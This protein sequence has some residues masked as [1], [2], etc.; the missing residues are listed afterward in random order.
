MNKDKIQDKLNELFSSY[1]IVFWNDPECE[2]EDML[3]SLH[4]KDVSVVRPDEI[5][6]LKTKVSLEIDNPN[7]K[8]LVYS[9]S[10]ILQY[11]DDWLLDIRLYSYQF[12]ADTASMIVEELGLHHHF[13]REHITKRK[14]FFASKERI[15]K[16]K[17]M[18]SPQDLEQDIDRKMLAVLVKTE[19]DRFFYIV[20]AVFNSYPKDEG[21]DVLP[22]RFLD[23]K[24]M[25]LEDV[26]WGLAKENFGYH[27]EN[28][29]LRHFLTCLL[30]SDLYVSIGSALPDSVRQFILPEIATHNA[31]VCMS[32]W[33]D[34]VRMTASYDQLSEMVGESVAVERYLSEISLDVLKSAVTFFAV[35]KICASKCRDYVLEHKDTL[36]KDY[37]ISICRTRQEMH[38]ANKRLG[39]E[40]IPREGL[41]S[42]HEAMVSAS[43]FID[44]KKTYEHGFVFNTSRDIYSEYTKDLYIFDKEYRNF[45]EY[46]NIADAKGWGILKDLKEYIED[47]YQNWFLEELTFRWEEKAELDNWFIEE[48]NNQYDFFGKYPEKRIGDKNATVFVIISD[49]LRYEAGVELNE[50]LNRRYRLKASIDTM[51]GVVP[52][53]TSIGMAALLPHVRLELSAKGE[54]LVDGKPCSGIDQRDEILSAKKGFA[55]KSEELLRLSR[56]ESR[57]LM[58]EKNIVYIYHNT[59]DAIGDDAK[60]ENKTFEA[61]RRAIDEIGDIISYAVNTLS[62]RFVFVTADHGFVY[63]DRFPDDTSRNIGSKFQGDLLKTNKRFVIGKNIQINE[64]VHRGKLSDTCGFSPQEDAMFAVPKG[65]SLFYFTGGARFFHGGMSLQEVVIPVIT[66][67]QVRGEEKQK[68]RRKTVGIQVLGQDH[69]ITTGKHRFEIIQTDAVSERVKAVTYKIG[70]YSENEP[71]SDIQILTFDSSSQDMASRKKEVILTLKNMQFATDKKYRLIFRNADT[72][73]EDL[74]VPV[75]IDR[76]FTSDF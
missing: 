2:F 48:T 10:S 45:L 74:S 4:L 37:I 9:A 62:A 54:I 49:A 57:E 42:I 70:I 63:R 56:D 6:Q 53:Y 29:N 38:W 43:N 8:F 32:E 51:F 52:S 59:I 11:N 58:R 22:S 34:S 20:H 76:I 18:V 44:K 67:E 21:L 39:S 71:V 5:G 55:I 7:E 47:V 23:I 19:N 64:D 41:W 14:K 3:E 68:T 61:I 60:T 13:L 35:E 72:D 46:A 75:R 65:M 17:N 15:A 24:K 50:T 69:R 30:M 66:V 1:R 33:R 40:I 12:Y 36:D 27:S 16:L 26:F 73:V 28:P 25:G 31:A